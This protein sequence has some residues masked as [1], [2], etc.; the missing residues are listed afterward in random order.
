MKT[1]KEL[2]EFVHAQGILQDPPQVLV[3]RR[4]SIRTFP[5]GERVALYRN[6]NLNLNVSIPYHPNSTYKP[7]SVSGVNEEEQIDENILHG[8][9]HAI[10]T[11]MPRD[12][13]FMN[14]VRFED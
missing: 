6:E 5:K 8:I 2:N 1:F 4:T 7:I 12:L 11:K 9:H 13:I 14:G 3:L 10:R